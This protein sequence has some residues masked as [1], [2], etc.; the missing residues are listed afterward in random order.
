M[1]TLLGRILFAAGLITAALTSGAV[2]QQDEKLGKVVFP[3][4]CDSNVQAEFD[5]GV[6]MLHSYWFLKARRTFDAILQQDPTCAMAH[7]GVAMDFLGN[8][9]AATPSR[10][11]AQAA[12]DA[13]EKARAAGPKTQRERDWIEALSAYFRNHDKIAVDVRLA[14]YKAAM[15]R[16]AQS[17]PDDYE[18]QTFYALT[19]QASAPK[20]DLTYANQIKSAALL[21]NLFEQNPQ[22]PGVTHYLI[23]AYDFAPLAEKGIASARRYAGIAPAVPHARHMPS[24][25]YSMVGLWEE[26]IASNA[27]SLEIQPDYYH[28][29]DFTVY[30]HLQ[31]AQDA[32]ADAMIK[33]SLATADRGDRPINFVHF[34][35]KAAMPARYVLER[36]DW[37]GA[38]AL[39]M[40]PTQYPMA[41][42]LIRFTRGLGMARTSDLAGAKDE[43]EAMKALRTTL[44]RADQSYWADRTEEQMLAISALVALKEG[45]RDQAL[46]FM[47]AAADSEDGSLKHVA[48]ENRLYPFRE[49]LAELLLE[50]GQPAAALNEFETA[51]KQ[52]PNRFRAFWGVARAADSAGDRQK[53]SEY[54]GK[55]VNLTKNADTERQ[56]IRE[57]QAY[58][59]RDNTIGGVRK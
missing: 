5:R 55:L 58:L 3:T 29:S 2:G 44:Q 54:F 26:S 52:T 30:A 21:E 7:W 50:T 12:W 56:E 35:A 59:R 57:A 1:N 39:P 24:H 53:A 6:A 38:A 51:L 18:V 10:A 4:S 27:S 32:K 16:M 28:A 49:L 17:Y 36:A 47:R 15:E 14:A 20:G 46:R 37:A 45:D 23:H 22:H 8:T 42:S 31:L 41:D 9:L 43:I 13:L 33:K 19:L 25:I 48:M 34:T 40:N 11:D